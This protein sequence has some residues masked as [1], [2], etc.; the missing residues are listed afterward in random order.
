MAYLKSVG[1]EYQDSE[2]ESGW[3]GTSYYYYNEK[4]SIM[5]DLFVLNDFSEIWIWPTLE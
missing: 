1:F 2:S 4:D 5:L 3:V